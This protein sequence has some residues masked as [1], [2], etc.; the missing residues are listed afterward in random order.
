MPIKVNITGLKKFKND[1]RQFLTILAEKHTKALADETR[2]VMKQKIADSITRANSTGNLEDNITSEP[3][4]GGHGVG[5]I[6]QLN[7]EAKYW[8]H[9]NYGSLAIG[10]KWEHRVPKGGFNPGNPAPQDGSSGA[11]WE[12]GSGPYSFV[13]TKPI[14]PSNFIDKTLAEIPFIV[15]KVLGSIN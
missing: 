9:W 5:N 15:R 10:A 11:R 4:Q 13:P 12:V 1:Q 3:I 14:E 8:R 7:R 2:D 6:E